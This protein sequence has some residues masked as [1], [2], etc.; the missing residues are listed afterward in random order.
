MP[1]QPNLPVPD[2]NPASLRCHSD[3][4]Y[5]RLFQANPGIST[6]SFSS[7]STHLDYLW[8]ESLGQEGHI[9]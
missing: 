7:T 1:P 6:H 2:M 9:T 4:A 5:S 3:G 8:R